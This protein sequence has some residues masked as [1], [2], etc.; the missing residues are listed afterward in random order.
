MIKRL[1]CSSALLLGAAAVSFTGSLQATELCSERVTIPFTFQADKVVLPSGTYRVEQDFGS[2]L[3]T[4]VNVETGQ[5]I[6]V[7]R[8]EPARHDGKLKLTFVHE[9]QTARLKS[10]A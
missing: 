8:R 2:P 5:R 4:L 6:Q 7:I 3:I 10:I 1:V 9:G